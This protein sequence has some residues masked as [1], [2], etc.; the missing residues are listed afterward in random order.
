M[1][2][3]EI[4]EEVKEVLGRCDEAKAFS[5]LTDAIQALQD[6]GDWNANIGVID[7]RAAISDGRNI[8][9]PRE[10]ETPLAVAVNC[11]PA[12]MR[13]EFYEFHL[14]GDGIESCG[15][16]WAWDDRGLSPTFMDIV[17]ASELI[18]VSS[19]ASDAGQLIRVLGKDDGGRDLRMQLEDGTWVDGLVVPVNS[20]ND[21]PGG[22]IAPFG[23]RL[24]YRLFTPTPMTN[25]LTASQHY[26]V[27]GALMQ[28]AID[29]GSVAS[30]LV[31]SGL[32]YV[33]AVDALRVS[34][35]TSRLDARTG[36]APVVVTSVSSPA[37]MTL[38]E[39]RGA[40]VRTKFQSATAITLADF[41]QVVLEATT[42]PEGVTAAT[43]YFIK[44]EGSNSFS[45]YET[46]ALA[47]AGES[48]INV[49]TEG[50]GITARALL[51]A[52]PYTTL[53][54]SVNHDMSTGDSV[55]VRNSGGA[56]PDP[57]IAG[58]AYY[59]RKL[60]ATSMQLHA[61]SSEAISGLNPIVLTTS[62]SGTNAVVKLVSATVV[63]G[64]SSQVTAAGHGLSDG[65]FVQF[66]S[67]GTLPAPIVQDTVYTCKTPLTAD[68]F[69]LKAANGTDTINITATGSGSLFVNVS[70][71]FSVG[72]TNAW[73]VE[74]DGRTTGN[75]IRFFNSTGA[76]PITSP[77]IDSATTY[78]LRVLSAD[79]VEIY[80]TLA[81]ALNL[82]ATTG[83]VAV[84]SAG[85]GTLFVS[86]DY[87]VT[88]VIRDSFLELEYNGFISNLSPIQ[89]TTD[90]SL[91]SPL[92]AA[93][94][95]LARVEDDGRVS[96]LTTAGAAVTLTS[97]GSGNHE[98]KIS[99]AFSVEPSTSLQVP[100][101][102]YATGDAVE[103]TSDGTLPAPLAE[104]TLYYL[105]AISPDAVEVY[106]QHAQA[107]NLTSTT[108]RLQLRD[109]GSGVHKIQQEQDPTLVASV[110]AIEKPV[111]S[112]F[113]NLYA[114]DDGNAT[115]LTLLADMHPSDTFPQYRRIRVGA[116]CASVRMKYRRKS[117]KVTSTRD[118]INLDSRMAI[119]MMVKSQDLLRKNFFE[120]SERYRLKAVDYMNKRNRALDGPR[121]P[122][123]Q[124]N[125]DVTTCPDDVMAD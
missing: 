90:G 60:T 32:Y 61:T 107:I 12:F 13:D 92:L 99:R 36:Q 28:L 87:A 101:S 35:H 3:S 40:A 125:A 66:S 94:D 69:T 93:T 72:F 62:G 19:L 67:T 111:T 83:R 15:V 21:F 50:S 73:R 53:S 68:T 113:V 110:S 5:R 86:I 39:N 38:T 45:I 95:Y 80:T 24:F 118:F 22:V 2:V 112:G 55:T 33:R 16:P 48:P 85:S 108:G 114:W 77:T 105:R 123:I 49:S 56:L 115:N 29:S 89:F 42:L 82:S 52:D 91:P 63:T 58:T 122:T 81:Y 47:E 26:L 34:L 96:V 104:S 59:V 119:T 46:Q 14:N 84:T 41:S 43:P 54:F 79:A 64:T 76:L 30:P 100:A 98:L 17:S 57:L 78:Y 124:I 10:V 121:S 31:N 74:T 4:L 65:S 7:I 70:R 117:F 25:L 1:F 109:V 97:I 6:E 103:F 71:A 11:R 51:R 18:A 116:D 20:L 75:A 44:N 88:A 9:L 102:Q 27:T 120:E 8:S 37:S 23:T 106:G